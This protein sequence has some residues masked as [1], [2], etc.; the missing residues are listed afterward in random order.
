MM[1][2]RLLFA[3]TLLS[4]GM[5]LNAQD[6]RNN[7]ILYIGDGF[8]VAPKT[9]AR[10]ALGQGTPTKRFSTDANFHVLALDALKYN[11]MV[12]THSLN[13]WIT[14][15]APGA[16]V[17]SSGKNGKVDNE[18]IALDPNNNFSPIETIL[19][20]A[21]K[22]GY[23]VGLVSTA[24]V[25]HATPAAFASHIWHRDLE[26]YIAAQLIASTQT[27]YET[28]FNSSP[29][30]AWH[31]LSTRDWELPSP[32]VGVELDVILGGGAAYFLPKGQNSPNAIIKDAMGMNISNGMN[33]VKFTGNRV[34][35]VDVIEYAKTQKNYVYVN[36]RDALTKVD[37]TQ[38]TDTN[39][40]KLLGLFHNSHVN[41]ELDRQ[42]SAAWEPSIE[43]MTRIAIEVLKKKSS[44]GFFLMV[45]SGR[46]DHLAHANSG[47]ITVIT[48][49][50]N[51]EYTVDSD[52]PSYVGGG[53]AV[54]GATPATSRQTAIYGSDYMIHEV[55]AY[56]YAVA[57]GAEFMKNTANGQT[58]I[59]TTSDHECGGFAVV[60]LHD[61]AD[62][63][64]N[65]TK[66]RTY[67]LPVTKSGEA[68]P[69]T[70]N[71]VNI[72]RGDGGDNGWYPQYSMVEFQ[73]KMYPRPTSSTGKRIVIAYGSN[74]LTNGNGIRAGGTPGN[75]TPQDI[76]VCGDDN[77]GTHAKLIAGN[78]L[79]DN[80]DLTPIMADFLNL[81]GFVTGLAELAPSKA[82]SSILAY[83]SPF[84]SN[85][86]VEF[87]MI[88]TG[89]VDVDVFNN[90]GVLVQ[91]V[92]KNKLC[93]IGRNSISFSAAGLQP[94]EYIIMVRTETGKVITSKVIKF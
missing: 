24:R 76:L 79:M 25:T 71:P 17:Y 28:I 74:P 56:D 38:F 72:S 91:K 23:A 33:D 30:P 66:I 69:A 94:G 6:Q 48:G 50:S 53:E 49:T 60:A 35:S 29:K 77:T 93:T 36:S 81:D 7:V 40:K 78:G 2:T 67:A 31:Y 42:L 59:L 68:K 57:A 26:N 58:L 89:D 34:D 39:D 65:G 47:G 92:A 37:L 9:A 43:E 64:K 73:G 55:V 85:L 88:N 18:V 10:M 84:T 63:Q 15:S 45:E 22:E 19:E 1:R 46:I 21:R 4:C 61:E 54:Y 41:Y 27:E 86:T 12:T 51:N 82:T 90:L 8:G 87:E 3:A 52:K 44:K 20:N 80:T 13:S 5:S 14:D 11:A 62:A 32:K 70:A 83:P 75:H 16:C